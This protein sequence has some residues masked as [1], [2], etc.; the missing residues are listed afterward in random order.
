MSS[1][2]HYIAAGNRGL[3]LLFDNF[4]AIEEYKSSECAQSDTAYVDEYEQKFPLL[5]QFNLISFLTIVL[6]AILI[7]I[8][9]I[10]YLSKRK[11]EKKAL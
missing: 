2:G 10:V 9:I 1:D 4:Q 3:F 11:M 8:P 7:G 6:I 5:S